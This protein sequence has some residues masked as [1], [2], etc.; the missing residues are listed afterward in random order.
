MESRRSFG[1]TIMVST[2]A[3][4]SCKPTSACRIRLLPSNRNGLVTIATHREP[5]SR[6]I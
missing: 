6:A 4:S 1:T 2:A 5:C 3:R